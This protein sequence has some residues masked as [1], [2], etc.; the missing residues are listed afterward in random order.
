MFT[1][2]SSMRKI[3]L[4]IHVTS[5]VGLLGAIAVFLALSTTG[6]SSEDPQIIRSTFLAMD[7]SSRFM[8]LPLA[9]ASIF[10]GVIQSLGTAWGLFRHYWVLAKLLLTVFATVILLIKMKLIGYAAVLAAETT[11]PLAELR[12]AGNELVFHAASGLFVLLIPVILSIYKPRGLTPYGRGLRAK[13]TIP[14]QSYFSMDNT[15]SASTYV[16]SRSGSFVISLS[17]TNV[18]AIISVIVAVH[19][20]VLHLLGGAQ[21]VH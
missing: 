15:E 3:A 10:S 7:L 19:F 14:V 6:V 17:R 13:S 5:S 9:V 21:V 12:A 8:I 1:M 11:L 4:T 20:I 2:T 18:V 16:K